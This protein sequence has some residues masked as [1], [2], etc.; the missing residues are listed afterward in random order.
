MRCECSLGCIMLVDRGGDGGIGVREPWVELRR[1][2]SCGLYTR[3]R[4]TAWTRTDCAS[5]AIVL[6]SATQRRLL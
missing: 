3:T 4:R 2:R 1:V 6:Q 5:F